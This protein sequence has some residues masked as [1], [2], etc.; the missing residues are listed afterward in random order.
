MVHGEGELGPFLLTIVAERGGEPVLERRASLSFVRG[1]TRV[2]RVLLPGACIGER[3]DDDP[4][5]TC[6]VGG[7]RS[8]EVGEGEL[9]PWDGR[10]P[11]LDAG[12][13]CRTDERCNGVD[14]D[15]DGE[16]DEGFD[17]QG[18]EEHCGG[19]GIRC[20]SEHARAA[21]VEGVCVIQACEPPWADC[22]GNATNGCET[23]TMRTDRHCGACGNACRPPA[24]ECCDGECGRC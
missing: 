21:C 16:T 19:C 8:V 10:P 6:A 22:D 12:G 20:A 24:R 13:A 11:P 18:D 15:C 3:C 7:C 1:E 4:D 17:T 23:D 14:D 2:L 5:R 9:E